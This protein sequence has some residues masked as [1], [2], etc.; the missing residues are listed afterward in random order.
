MHFRRVCKTVD[1]LLS[2]EMSY[3][4]SLKSRFILLAFYYNNRYIMLVVVINA[5]LSV[6]TVRLKGK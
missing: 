6:F 4:Q 3:L 2:Q 5:K 1:K